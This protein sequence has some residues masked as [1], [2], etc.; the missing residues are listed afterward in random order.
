MFD[1]TEIQIQVCKD[2]INEIDL[3]KAELSKLSLSARSAAT[4]NGILNKTMLDYQDQLDEL[5]EQRAIMDKAE[6]T[7]GG[8]NRLRITSKRSKVTLRCQNIKRTW[9]FKSTDK[10]QPPTSDDILYAQQAAKAARDKGEGDLRKSSEILQD[11]LT[12]YFDYIDYTT[13]SIIEG[14]SPKTKAHIP[15]ENNE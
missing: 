9:D 14:K 15:T 7:L 10:G 4:I 13:E 8:Q 11:L 6:E 3:A 12:E 5:L 1:V 2:G